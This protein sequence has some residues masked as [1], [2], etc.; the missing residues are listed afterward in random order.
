VGEGSKQKAGGG[1]GGGR[2]EGGIEAG[3]GA[4]QK[5]AEGP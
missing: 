5:E 3:Y 2:R 4:Y 1:E